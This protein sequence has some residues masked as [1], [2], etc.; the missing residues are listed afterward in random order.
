MLEPSFHALY[1]QGRFRKSGADR[2][3][4][5]G[6]QQIER[7]A[8]A[9]LAFVLKHDPEFR[10]SFLNQVC[11]CH[12]A[13][14]TDPVS[15]LVELETAGCGDLILRKEDNS[16]V[17]ALEFKVGANLEKE[18]QDPR[19]P[20]FFT[21]GYGKNIK[22]QFGPNSSYIVVQNDRSDFSSVSKMEPSC[23]GKSWSD[24]YAC[25]QN[26]N[27]P[28]IHDL[29][30]SLGAL[31]ITE[32]MRMNTKDLTLGHVALDAAKLH[33]LLETVAKVEGFK[34]CDVESQLQPNNRGYYVRCFSAGARQ[35]SWHRLIQPENKR[36]GSFGYTNYGEPAL[37]V[38][39][40]CGT[41]KAAETIRS[42]LKDRFPDDEVYNDPENHAWIVRMAKKSQG[43]QEWFISVFDSLVPRI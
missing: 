4:Q 5:E 41:R 32:F 1:K 35:S 31:G 20:E 39:I 2:L 19:N 34:S 43:D 10:K 25:I 8:V 18:K 9:M 38:W 15:F 26:N 6:M 28:L 29:F 27:K 17:Y 30:Q 37:E 22:A 3:S 16:K 13:D 7:F 12:C 11:D 42:L 14:S 21:T 23:I 33:A 36:L 40:E 24:I